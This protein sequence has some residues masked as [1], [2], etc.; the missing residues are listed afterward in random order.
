V[1]KDIPISLKED[2]RNLKRTKS[3][4]NKMKKEKNHA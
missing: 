3:Y 1:Q 4:L 2:K